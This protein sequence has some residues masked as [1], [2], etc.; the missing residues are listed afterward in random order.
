MFLFTIGE[1]YSRDDD[2]TSE[3]FSMAR[4]VFRVLVLLIF[5]YVTY[6][7]LKAVFLKKSPFLYFPVKKTSVTTTMLKWR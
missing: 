3:M 2:I 4:K 1:G 5:C 7:Q 6:L